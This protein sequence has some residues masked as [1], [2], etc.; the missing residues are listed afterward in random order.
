VPSSITFED[1]RSIIQQ[2]MRWPNRRFLYSFVDYLVLHNFRRLSYDRFFFRFQASVKMPYALGRRGAYRDTRK[3]VSLSGKDGL[4]L[5]PDHFF[6]AWGHPSADVGYDG[7][8]RGILRSSP[9]EM[10]G[11]GMHRVEPTY[12]GH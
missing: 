10:H 6:V 1:L 7:C 5:A 8:Q 4:D 2:T 3:E 9:I 12:Y 11:I